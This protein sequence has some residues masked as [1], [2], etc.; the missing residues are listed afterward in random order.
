MRKKERVGW[1]ELGTLLL[2]VLF[3]LFVLVMQNQLA[4]DLATGVSSRVNIDV[5][6]PCEKGFDKVAP[7]GYRWIS[8]LVEVIVRS[9]SL[10]Q[11]LATM[12]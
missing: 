6:V 3:V 11:R 5:R 1:H 7:A 10:R 9:D 4:S 12:W 8:F 2:V